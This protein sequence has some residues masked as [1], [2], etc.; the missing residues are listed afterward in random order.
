[1]TQPNAASRAR[2]LLQIVVLVEGR[3]V[4]GSYA[5][6]ASLVRPT[7]EVRWTVADSKNVE[8]QFHEPH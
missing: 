5:D 3:M 4:V 7:R 1:A 2:Q 8:G 6:V